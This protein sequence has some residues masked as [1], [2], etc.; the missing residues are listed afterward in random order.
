MCCA[1]SCLTPPRLWP[2]FV[3]F[4]PWRRFGRVHA[5]Q[6]IRVLLATASGAS[7]DGSL[8]RGHILSVYFA[9]AQS[10]TFARL[11]TTGAGCKCVVSFAWAS[12]VFN[13]TPRNFFSRTLCPSTLPEVLGCFTRPRPCICALHKLS[14]LSAR[15]RTHIH[16]SL[17]AHPGST[18]QSAI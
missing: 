5:Q 7:A 12:V 6:N 8:S 9:R 16:T 1:V 2:L 10:F 13:G 11:T 14:P 4:S 15:E 18:R 17:Q 3:H